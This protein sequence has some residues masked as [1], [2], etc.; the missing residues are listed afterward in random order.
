MKAIAEYFRDLAAD[1]RYFGAEPPTP[2]A[3]MLHQIAEREMKRR[4]EAKIQDNGVVLRAS[5]SDESDTL[6]R[7]DAPKAKSAPKAD[8]LFEEQDATSARAAQSSPIPSAVRPIAD[9]TISDSVAAK[10][11]RIRNAMAETRASGETTRPSAQLAGA[12]ALAEA[13]AAQK[14]EAEARA[15]AE[16]ETA[17]KAEAEARAKAEAEAAQKA[18]AEALAKAEAEAAQM[19][20]AEA[21]AKSEAE[22]EAARKTETNAEANKNNDTAADEAQLASF[23]GAFDDE[24]EALD[25]G[26]DDDMLDT[27]LE[28][29]DAEGDGTLMASLATVMADD[30]LSPTAANAPSNTTAKKPANDEAANDD[31]SDDL[32]VDLKESALDAGT[33]TSD[34]SIVDR[35]DGSAEKTE[36]TTNTPDARPAA[37]DGKAT[38]LRA[39]ARVIKIRRAPTNPGPTEPTPS[40]RAEETPTNAGTLS[41]EDEADLMR[42]LAALEKEL[43]PAQNTKSTA[44]D[45]QKDAANADSV[46][47]VRPQRPMS[48]RRKA[49]EL[50]SSEDD[51][52]VKRLL[53]Q[54]NSELEGTEN[55]RRL[56]AIAH[57]KAAVA[58]TVADRKEGVDQG[59]TEEMRMNPYR[60]DLERVVR[61][62]PNSAPS[63]TSTGERPAPLMLVSEQRI[64]GPRV[65][66]S[67]AQPHVTPV[68]PRRVAANNLAFSTDEDEALETGEVDIEDPSL[69]NET[70]SFAEYAELLGAESLAELLETA[71][72]Y[73]KHIQGRSAV[74]RP[75]LLQHVLSVQP[76]LESERET[77]LRSFG[78]LLREG[79]IEKVRPGQFALGETSPIQAEA[80][81]ISKG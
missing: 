56:S 1:D 48:S 21:R 39:R 64:D 35:T 51:A 80:R 8:A 50:S 23:A 20:E 2:D 33:D 19:A 5:D 81:R 79:R 75:Q 18:E 76:A 15:K 31:D 17:Q 9:S 49:S 78:T 3:A 22:A 68:R 61:P 45:A 30:N 4:V 52:S 63:G 53:D 73:S 41:P 27:S 60:D 69:I 74:S 66:P 7:L 46:A 11:S 10:L 28:P 72:A 6:S 13:E 47:P 34:E 26:F 24:D 12:S 77:V 44:T 42:E 38:L 55:R 43:P 57:L 16:A 40:P 32:A 37:E 59:P 70:T 25:G 62:R 67:T 14:A 58:A 71:A 65:K 36:S 29:L 54:T